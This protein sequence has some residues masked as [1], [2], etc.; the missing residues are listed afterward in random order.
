MAGKKILFICTGN[1][2]RSSMATFLARDLQQKEFA[3]SGHLFDSAGLMAVEG[4]PASPEAIAVLAEIG[5]DLLPHRAKLF[6]PEMVDK[7]DLIL[8]MTGPHRQWI[9]NQLPNA[10]GKVFSLA[11]F[12]GAS[13]RDIMDPFGGDRGT[14]ALTRDH[15]LKML[16]EMMQ[17]LEETKES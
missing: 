6:R 17:K 15:L 14:Y 13:D 4:M 16:S 11:E 8:T 7:A 10:E 2:C 3:Q 1:T 5:I 9:I 12:V